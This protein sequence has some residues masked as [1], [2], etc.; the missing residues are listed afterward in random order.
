LW[1]CG[2]RLIGGEW[3]VVVYRIRGRSA[4]SRDLGKHN[5]P[6]LHFRPSRL[7]LSTVKALSAKSRPLSS[8][9][10]PQPIQVSRTNSLSSHRCWEVQE[11]HVTCQMVP[12]ANHHG[13]KLDAK[14]GLSSRCFEQDLGQNLFKKKYLVIYRRRSGIESFSNRR[15][16][17][18]P[19]STCITSS[20]IKESQHHRYSTSLSHRE[21]Q[22]PIYFCL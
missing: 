18:L 10:K 5:H 15:Q 1:A 11:Q 21:D 7:V 4:E 6:S 2:K 8:F 22:F 13:W 14:S 9:E 12:L 17:C 16:F 20:D 19:K 3:D